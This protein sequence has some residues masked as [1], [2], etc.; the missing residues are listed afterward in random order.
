MIFQLLSMVSFGISNCFWEKPVRQMPALNLILI[1]SFF[2]SCCFAMLVA[3]LEFKIVHLPLN[4]LLQFIDLTFLNISKAIGVCFV[5]YWGLYFFLK[6]MQH[7]DARISIIMGTAGALI[8][9]LIGIFFYNETPTA[10]SYVYLIVFTIGWWFIEN[11]RPEALRFKWSKGVGYAIVCMFFWRSAGFFPMVI[12]NVGALYF[13][14]ILEITVC[15]TTLILLLIK[16]ALPKIKVLKQQF[17]IFYQYILMLVICGFCGVL[18][19]NIAITNTELY[20]FAIVGMLQPL[21]SVVLGSF[22]FKTKL[23][24]YQGI[25]ILIL[26]G[27]MLFQMLDVV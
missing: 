15:L 13:S 20:T 3:L 18:F 19:F 27:G 9:V 12:E 5:N 26:L 4:H 8:F 25:G 24:S 16:K 7:T 23:S 21:T 6:S 22:M 1:R 17:L 14:L 10:A 11:L 2:T